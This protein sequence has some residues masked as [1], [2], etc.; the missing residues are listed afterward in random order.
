[1]SVEL[2]GGRWSW[3]NIR[4]RVQYLFHNK[5][6]H[7][8]LSFWRKWWVNFWEWSFR[9]WKEWIYP[10]LMPRTYFQETYEFYLRLRVPPHLN[11][12]VFGDDTEGYC[13][14]VVEQGG[15]W[16]LCCFQGDT[17]DEAWQEMVDE[18][19][20]WAKEAG[21]VGEN[22]TI[23]RHDHEPTSYDQTFTK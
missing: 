16:D 15:P 17:A 4:Y 22:W 5:L 2:R 1:M 8:E 21:T 9:K 11:G 7:R 6:R 14:H 10:H 13:V 18:L 20:Y 19:T 12:F 3:R 23:V